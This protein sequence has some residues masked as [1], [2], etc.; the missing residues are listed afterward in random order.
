MSNIYTCIDLGTD[1][2]KVITAE[3]INDKYN[4][5]ARV[6]HKS[7]GIKDGLITDIKKAS[8]SVKEAIDEI[9]DMLGFSIDKALLTINPNDVS[10]EMTSGKVNVILYN[11]IT[12]NDIRNCI[13]NAIEKNL[14]DEYELI[15]ATPICFKVDDEESI[16]DPK[17]MKGSCLEAKVVLSFMKKELVYRMLEVIK[18]SGVEIVD[19]TYTTVGDYYAFK[20]RKKDNDVGAI[21][22][23]GESTTNVSI[24]NKGIMIK[25]KKVPIGSYNVDKDISYIFKI[26]NSESRKLKEKYATSIVG[27]DNSKET[28]TVSFSNGDMKEIS[29]YSITKVVESRV[30]EILNLAKKEIKNLTNRK[31]RYIIITGGL[32]EL[33]DFS[34]VVQEEFG[35]VAS[36]ATLDVMG[37][38]HNKYSSC[39]GSIIYFDEKL[40]LRGKS[41]NMI[42]RENI[43][44]LSN[45]QNEKEVNNN[46]ISKVFG[47]FFDN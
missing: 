35:F 7:S 37:I 5:L 3:K 8:I 2:I 21:I 42:S 10:I 44:K 29:K 16:F 24:Y 14:D 33:A 45:F 34:Y 38:R 47:H 36:V 32:N 6:S 26:K 15:T 20:D 41:Y 1:T 13:N 43:I 22:N 25:N 39:Y 12:G 19:I 23:I 31:I 11:E 4:V 28:T 9:S 27:D 30:R 18:L 46:I 17:G 40:T